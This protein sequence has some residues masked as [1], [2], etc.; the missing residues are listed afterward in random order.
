[1]EIKEMIRK[2]YQKADI[3]VDDDYI[4]NKMKSKKKVEQFKILYKQEEMESMNYILGKPLDNATFTEDEVELCSE[5]DLFDRKLVNAC[6]IIYENRNNKER[7]KSFM[8]ILE[9]SRC[10]ECI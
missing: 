5:I 10:S 9:E 2:V 6:R 8:K 4:E 3:Q 7:L 1:M